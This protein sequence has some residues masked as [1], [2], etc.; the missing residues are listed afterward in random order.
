MSNRQKK[1]KTVK[2]ALIVRVLMGLVILFTAHPSQAIYSRRA[3]KR[4]AHNK[5]MQE[6]E[7]KRKLSETTQTLMDIDGAAAQDVA[8]KVTQENTTIVVPSDSPSDDV[9]AAEDDEFD[10]PATTDEILASETP[11]SDAA[12][13][14]LM[15]SDIK[16]SRAADDNTQ[17][18][19]QLLRRTEQEL[20]KEDD[21]AVKVAPKIVTESDR[22]QEKVDEAEMRAP[23]APIDTEDELDLV[24]KRKLV[25]SLVEKGVEFF[26]SHNLD[27]VFNAFSHGKEFLK[28][29]LYLFVYDYLGNCLAHGQESDL[30]WKSLIDMRD[31]YGTA[32]VKSLIEK[33]QKGGGWVTYQWRGSSKVTYVKEVVKEGKYYLIGCGYYP[34]SKADAVVNLVKG[35]VGFF[36]DSLARGAVPEEI[37]STLSYPKGRFVQGDLYLYALNWKGVLVAQG[38]RPGLIGTNSWNVQDTQGKYSTQEIIKKLQETNEGVWVTYMSKNATKIAYAEKITDKKGNNYAIACG[39]YPDANRTQVINLVKNG[40]EYMKKNGK[41]SAS[42]AFSDRRNNDFRYGDLYLTVYDM[43]GICQAN[44]VNPDLV[45]VSQWDIQDEDGRYMVREMI[46]K[47]NAGGGWVD[48]KLKNAFL[49]S[50]VEKINLGI[51]SFIIVS[52]LYPVSKKET[53]ILMVK[54]AAGFFRT[55]SMIDAL[56]EFVKKNSS[57]VRGDLF[58]YVFDANGICYAYGDDYGLIWRNMMNA[59]DDTGKQFI[60]LMINTA[61][62]GP[63]S[64]SYIINDMRKVVYMEPVEKEGKFFIVGSGF[65]V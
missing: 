30:I 41:T 16:A 36:N 40:Y 48:F 38:D 58:T 8:D 65:Y 19:T 2:R 39:Y 59:T 20:K 23:E 37:F 44:G 24:K 1:E 42:L 5:Q 27:Y 49:S 35:A 18:V 55:N 52:G 13:D 62:S 15:P 45:G 50:Y 32:I 6:T 43:K 51:D 57:F 60:K 26:K 9:Q 17:E 3:A 46:D 28:G 56:R 21:V 63:G 14:Y 53:M 31:T 34:Q 25:V 29:E 7:K 11:I 64:V 12:K 61:K 47:G 33:S 54:G 4:Y 22:Q 10:R